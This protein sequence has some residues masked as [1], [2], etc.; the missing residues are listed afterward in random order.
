[1]ASTAGCVMAVWRRSSS[2]LATAFA[3]GCVDEDVLAQRFAKQRGH[4]A[5]RFGESFGHDGFSGAERL[6]HIHVLRALAGIEER[7]LGRRAVAAED[8]LRAQRLPDCGLFRC[9]RF[10]RL[11]RFVRQFGGVGIV[12]GQ[13]LGRAQVGFRRRGWSAEPV[14]PRPLAWTFCRRSANPAAEAAPITSAPRSGALREVSGREATLR[15]LHRHGLLA[16]MDGVALTAN[17]TLAIAVEPVRE[18]TPPAPAWKLVPPNP[19]ALT[20]ARRTPS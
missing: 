2:A 11:G 8:A 1:M 15:R 6:Q 16:S 12:D 7:H 14:L 19:K 13:A 20:P 9:Q 18:C 5:I 4:D 10:E 3:I 17:R